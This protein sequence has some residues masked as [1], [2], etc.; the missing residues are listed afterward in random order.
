MRE[1]VVAR[2]F[3]T[4]AVSERLVAIIRLAAFKLAFA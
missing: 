1:E 2:V 4:S 3:M